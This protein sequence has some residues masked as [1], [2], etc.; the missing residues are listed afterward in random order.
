MKW[1]FLYHKDKEYLE[2]IISGTI[3]NDELNQMAVE[4]WE[5]LRKLNCRKILFDF[6]QITNILSTVEIY[7]RPDESEKHG[8]LRANYTAAV[9]PDI[10]WTEFSFMETVY[11]N[12]G[13]DL[14]IFNHKADALRY[15]DSM[16]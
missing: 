8:V 13:Y 11:Q 10:Y 7:H 14:H 9:V 2:I 1:E 5:E 15:L 4:R 12:R 16:G 3:S 6:T